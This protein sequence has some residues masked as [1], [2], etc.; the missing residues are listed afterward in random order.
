MNV[1]KNGPYRITG[2]ADLKDDTWGEGA[3]R[4]HYALCR[5]GHSKNKPF[6][7]G[8]HWYVKFT[9]DDN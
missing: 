2:G 9:D 1:S 6:C 8:S 3:S 7:D 4:E 5:C